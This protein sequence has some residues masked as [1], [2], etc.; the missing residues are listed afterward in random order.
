MDK[1]QTELYAEQAHRLVDYVIESA[2]KKIDAEYGED[3]LTRL[4][5]MPGTVKQLILA[6]RKL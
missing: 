5:P 1:S 3:A 4:N 2:M 6:C